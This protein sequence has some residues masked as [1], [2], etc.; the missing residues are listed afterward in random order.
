MPLIET[1]CR[2]KLTHFCHIMRGGELEKYIGVLLA[3]GDEIWQ[4]GNFTVYIYILFVCLCPNC[5][6]IVVH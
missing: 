5:L 4:Q 3:M 1:I 6:S 2:H